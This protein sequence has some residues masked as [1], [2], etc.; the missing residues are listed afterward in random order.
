VHPALGGGSVGA[1]LAAHLW[2]INRPFNPNFSGVVYVNG[3]V[4]I[5]GVVR[6]Q[7]TV[8]ASG[9]VVLADDLI[10]VTAPG[11]VP[12]C[13]Q[14]GAVW[15]DILGVLTAQFFVIGDNNV[16]P[17]FPVNGAYVTRPWAPDL[18]TPRSARA[19]QLA[20]V[21]STWWE[22]RFRGKTPPA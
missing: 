18:P 6:G 9:N 7:V 11:S 4:G 10:Y 19:A 1:E 3:S 20:G 5:S 15:A 8:A 12:D 13:N 16:N 14:N 2:P 22:P 17:P 21:A